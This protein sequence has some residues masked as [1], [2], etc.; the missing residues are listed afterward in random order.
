MT[1]FEEKI[2]QKLTKN[3]FELGYT[4]G[5]ILAESSFR[6]DLLTIRDKEDFNQIV[7]K[8]ST[9]LISSSK[10]SN[11]QIEKVTIVNAFSGV[12]ENFTRRSKFYVS[13]FVDGIDGRRTI[14]KVIATT[15]F[16]YFLCLLPCVAFGVLNANNT[17]NHIGKFLFIFSKNV[18]QFD[19]NEMPIEHSL[20]KLL[21]DC[22]LRSLP[23]SLS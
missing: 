9:N 2:F 4:L 17:S 11:G 10:V 1:S 19:H 16:L 8:R 7:D 20:D 21:E 18:I 23:V 15:F 13:D 14:N 22:F 3:C 12:I 6:Q 5:T